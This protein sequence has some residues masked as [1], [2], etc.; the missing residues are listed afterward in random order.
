MDIFTY[1]PQLLFLIP[2]LT[3][4]ILIL[5]RKTSFQRNAISIL[6]LFCSLIL[7][8]FGLYQSLQGNISVSLI[9]GWKAPYG[10]VL[11]MDTMSALFLLSMNTVFFS[12]LLYS[13]YEEQSHVESKTRLPLIFLLQTGV[14]LSLL[15][16]DF[17]N[18][19]VG[20]EI[21]LCASYAL[22]ALSASKDK[23]HRMFDYMTLSMA[24]SFLLIVM[25]GCLYAFTGHLNIAGAAS[26][27][28]QLDHEP[29]VYILGFLA[30]LIFGLKAGIF[31][32]YFWLPDSYPILPP[33]L[34]GLFGGI[35]TKVGFYIL[36]RLFV[37]M[38][39]HNLNELYITAGVVA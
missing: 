37:T 38:L 7:S 2:L 29:Q 1:I 17:F 11:V 31:P 9:G 35:L 20:I 6:T 23:L 34:A 12:A 24:A 21:M 22:M 27:L 3:S 14:T 10:I 26:V 4:V 8:G 15:T 30:L 25:A 28:S 5:W 18:L 13:F 19:F 39:P 16:G 33:S 36:I 32:L